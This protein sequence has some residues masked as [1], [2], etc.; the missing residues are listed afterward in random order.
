MAIETF[1][2]YPEGREGPSRSELE[3]P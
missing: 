1:V 3:Q 2:L